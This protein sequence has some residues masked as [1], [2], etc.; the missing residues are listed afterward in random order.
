MVRK[1]I[2]PILGRNVSPHAFRHS[3][4]THVYEESGDIRLVQHL[5]GHD[6]IRTTQIYTHVT[7]RKERERLEQYLGESGGKR[8]VNRNRE[9]DA[10]GRLLKVRE[11]AP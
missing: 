10:R 9:R 3:Y 6:S 11:V 8:P 7:P 2:P 1:K 4:S 5:V